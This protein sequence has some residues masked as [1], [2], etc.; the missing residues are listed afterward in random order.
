MDE[1]QQELPLND[2]P[3]LYPIEGGRAIAARDV[4]SSM[5]VDADELS[6][7][8]NIAGYA[9]I[10]WD[11]EGGVGSAFHLGSRNP[12]SPAMLPDVLRQRIAADIAE[13]A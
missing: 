3:V 7:T 6:C 8:E 12:F 10:V 13:S 11:D 5:S 2:R 4:M 9:I 1:F